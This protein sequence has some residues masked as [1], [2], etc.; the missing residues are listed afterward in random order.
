M[1][2]NQLIPKVPN[3]RCPFPEIGGKAGACRVLFVQYA[4]LPPLLLLLTDQL[5]EE[6][7]SQPENLRES[8]RYL[9]IKLARC[10]FTLLLRNYK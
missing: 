5:H 8:K 6:L 10:T 9:K 7:F 2:I 3:V 1:I 4:R